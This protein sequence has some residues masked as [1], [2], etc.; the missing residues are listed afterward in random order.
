MGSTQQAGTLGNDYT[1]A[2]IDATGP[3][4]SPRARAVIGSLIRYLHDFARENRITVDEWMQAVEMMNWAGQ[5][6]N[7]KRN[8]GQLVCDVLGLE[9]Y[10]YLLSCLCWNPSG[11]NVFASYPRLALFCR[12]VSNINSLVD[13]ITSAMLAGSSLGATKTAILGPFYRSDVPKSP[14]DTSIIRT[15]PADGEVVYMHGI[16]TDANTGLPLPG[17]QID[18]WQCSTN[19]LYEQQDPEQA[20]FNLRGRLVSDLRGY[21]GLYCLRPVPY[22]IPYDGMK[23]KGGEG[24]KSVLSSQRPLRHR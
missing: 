19:G 1:N 9:S 15:M 8:E 13:D 10:V 24:G 12:R 3:K 7:A 6:S 14:N 4:A 23:K 21:Y 20:E 18:I 17:V 16:V 22:P 11:A 5:M 2:V